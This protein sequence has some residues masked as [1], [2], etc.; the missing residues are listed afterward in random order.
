MPLACSVQSKLVA[1]LEGALRD[2]NEACAL[3]TLP[4]CWY[5]PQHISLLRLGCSLPRS[6]K[7]FDPEDSKQ[8][9]WLWIS[10]K[11]CAYVFIAV[12]CLVH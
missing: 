4:S 8:Y 1:K 6:E 11:G 2:W 3:A 9:Q 10:P 7:E 5:P 12:R